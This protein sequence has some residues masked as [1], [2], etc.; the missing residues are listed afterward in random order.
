MGKHLIAVACVLLA[1]SAV[2]FH[3]SHACKNK[4]MTRESIS[5]ILEPIGMLSLQMPFSLVTAVV[6]WAILENI[7]GFD[8]SLPDA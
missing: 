5:L 7:L 2:R 6:V 3:V 4:D 1:M 8:P